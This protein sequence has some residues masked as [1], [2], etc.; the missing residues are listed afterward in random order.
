M[1]VNF[2]LRA[3]KSIHYGDVDDN[4]M[5]TIFSFIL[6]LDNDELNHYFSTNTV[7]S[8]KNDLELCIEIITSLIKIYELEEKYE[9]CNV[10]LNKKKEAISINESKTNEYV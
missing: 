9:R 6:K 3:I 5:E 2:M 8:Y 4:D 7:V 1:S 10:L